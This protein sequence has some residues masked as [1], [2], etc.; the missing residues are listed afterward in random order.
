VKNRILGLMAAALAFGRGVLRQRD[1]VVPYIATVPR[2]E[3]DRR[4]PEHRKSR[5]THGPQRSTRRVAM[6]LRDA[7]KRRN[8]LR[9]KGKR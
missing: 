2:D 7:R 9:E 6:D 1:T 5:A 3:R 4:I 8:Q